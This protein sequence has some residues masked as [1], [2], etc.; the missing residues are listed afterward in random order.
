M[1]SEFG[2]YEKIPKDRQTLTFSQLDT[3][4]IQLINK[5]VK[6]IET[7]NS[8]VDKMFG[9]M[10]FQIDIKTNEGESFLIDAI[11]AQ[12][13]WTQLK[14]CELRK[15]LMQIEC[16]I[17]F[18]CVSQ[19]FTEYMMVNKI[20]KAVKEFASSTYFKSFGTKKRTEA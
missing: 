19:E 16:L 2:V 9:S 5:I 12:D 11:K 17:F 20:K 7:N 10:Y 3:K 13:F 15:S 6:Y 18:F 4:G 8:S 1:M 14:E